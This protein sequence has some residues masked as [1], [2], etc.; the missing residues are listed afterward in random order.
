MEHKDLKDEVKKQSA[1]T[2]EVRELLI[3]VKTAV[4]FIKHK[5]SDRHER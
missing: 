3:K 1:R 4:E 5:V 2:D